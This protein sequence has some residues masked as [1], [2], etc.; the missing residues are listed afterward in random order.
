MREINNIYLIGMSGV[1]KSSCAKLLAKELK[2]R[3]VSTDE[4]IKKRTSQSI[5]ELLEFGRGRG[6]VS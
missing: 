5:D 2:W 1:G 3:R 4:L 6:A